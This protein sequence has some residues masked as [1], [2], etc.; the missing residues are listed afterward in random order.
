MAVESLRTLRRRLR[1]VK[2][3]R[4]ITRAMEMVAASKLRRAQAV[5]MAGRPYAAKLQE[6]LAHL[7][8]GSALGEH[9]LFRER[10]G[11]RKVLVIFTA[12][13][14][15]SGSF[16]ANIIKQAEELLRSEPETQWQ[17]VCIGRKGRDHFRRRQWP[18]LESVVGLR[19]HPELAEARRIATLLLDLYNAGRCDS[20]RL[21]YSAFISMVVYR[22]TLVRYLPMSPESLGLK[23]DEES[24]RAARNIDYLLEPSAKEVFDAILPRYLSSRIYITMA[25][26]ATSEHSARMIA[27][28]NATKNCSEMSDALTL[29]MNKAR[30]NTITKELLDI[31]GGAEA[32]KQGA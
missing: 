9:P 24:E 21:L 11:R 25:E 27:M 30:Q 19:G 22:P 16:N 28:N 12:D 29:R 32:Q 2:N 26:V 23:L 20:I 3:I 10:Q 6:L 17:L 14:G 18:I 4:Q 8:E 1:A 7:A 13:R 15:L 5:L 31:V